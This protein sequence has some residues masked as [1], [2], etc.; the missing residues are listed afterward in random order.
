MTL[1]PLESAA[2]L[3]LAA[4]WL[5]LKENYQW[6]DFGGNRLGVTPALLKIMVQRQSNFIRLFSSFED[7]TPIGIA[8]LTNV[9]RNMRTGTLWGVVGDK[10][11]R[12][13]GVA[14]I[15]GSRFMTLAFQELGLHSINT[16]TVEHNVSVRT[17]K[18]L[19]F[20]FVGRQR[21]CHF[22]DGQP[23]DRLLFDLL[24]SE[25]RELDHIGHPALR[26]RVEVGATRG[27]SPQP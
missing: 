15:A 1:R 27:L 10:S 8:G 13:R 14:Q 3:E 21:Q 24:A 20:R 26:G 25:H 7:A 22:I 12:H 6:L 11:F 18:R 17:V 4:G 9:D 2:D 5:R 23:Y 16:W 19:G